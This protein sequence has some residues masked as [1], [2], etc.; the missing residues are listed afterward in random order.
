M[1]S[2]RRYSRPADA[3]RGGIPTA[4]R[5]PD[6]GSTALGDVRLLPAHAVPLADGPEAEHPPELP[7]ATRSALVSGTDRPGAAVGH[8]CRPTDRAWRRAV[9]EILGTAR[10]FPHVRVRPRQG[11][12]PA[13]PA[14]WP[15][16]GRPVM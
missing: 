16:R 9:P 11:R 1:T 12:E 4:P 15:G 8:A 13:R 6:A 2:T 7:A 5:R 3:P 14:T 10:R